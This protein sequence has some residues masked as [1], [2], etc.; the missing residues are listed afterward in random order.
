MKEERLDST[1]KNRKIK[2]TGIT[3]G[4]KKCSLFLQQKQEEV[5][6]ISAME[7]FLSKFRERKK[8]NWCSSEMIQKER[9]IQNV[10]LRDYNKGVLIQNER[11][12]QSVELYCILCD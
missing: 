2:Q 10:A 9:E 12:F 3:V 5:F 7:M 4:E 6:T 11:E 1:T 8:Q